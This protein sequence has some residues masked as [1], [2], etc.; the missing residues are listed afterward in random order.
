MGSDLT[1][2]LKDQMTGR[3]D[4]WAIR[5]VYSQFRQRLYTIYPTLSKVQNIG[6]DSTAT[7]TKDRFNRFNTLLDNSG[8]ENFSFSDEVI[9]HR[10]YLSQFLKQFSVGTRI[11]FKILNKLFS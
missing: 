1:K 2:M 3:I 9:L 10:Q 5:W 8:K 7:N 11:K 4:S 6:T